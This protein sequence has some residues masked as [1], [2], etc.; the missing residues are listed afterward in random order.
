[1][2]TFDNFLT[3]ITQRYVVPNI[4]DTV[5]ASN[6]LCLKLLGNPIP[7][8]GTTYVQPIQT[9]ASTAG[10]S[11]N[12]YDTFSTQRQNLTNIM[13]FSPKAYYQSVTLSNLEIA[14]NK[15]QEG[16]INV[17]ESQ[18][19]MAKNSMADGIGT[20]FYSDGTGNGGADFS[21]LKAAVDDG[22]V[23]ATYGGLLRSTYTTIKANRTASVGNLTLS[24][25][26]TMYNSCKVGTDRPD[27][28]VTTETVWNYYES[29]TQPT[30]VTN[31]DG[32][33]Q[34]TMDG[35]AQNRS[36]LKGEIGFDALFYRGAP[37][38]ADEKCSSGYMYFLNM[39][40]LKW[41]SLPHP[42]N[43]MVGS[44]SNVIEGVY[45]EAG[46]EVPVFSW[47]DWKRPTN[48]DART[49]QFILYGELIN[50][51]PNRSGVL[52]GITGV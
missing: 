11:F 19:E 47:T 37:I 22:T 27:L 50:K 5:L 52:L 43:T 14:V 41:V 6:V 9:S 29:L 25:M 3:D 31:V 16:V 4:V 24:G 44:G 45:S 39:N 17:I 23:T 49:G 36:A 8:R 12:P 18:M 38:V 42:E 26:G 33:R 13:S 51:N 30:V 46:H 28:I 2:A 15:G 34:V 48:Q 35:S 10:G 7:W 21:G 40:Y 32:Y 1:M 20:I